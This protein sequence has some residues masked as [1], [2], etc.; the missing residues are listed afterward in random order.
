M[1]TDTWHLVIE[2]PVLI[3]NQFLLE[4]RRISNS[5]NYMLDKLKN[6]I[7]PTHLVCQEPWHVYIGPEVPGL[8]SLYFVDNHKTDE[9]MNRVID[10]LLEHL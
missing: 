1:S 9:W 6:I 5:N 8:E 2:Q 10:F 4:Y 3:E 7:D